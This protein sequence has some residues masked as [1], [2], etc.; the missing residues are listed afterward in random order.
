VI[1]PPRAREK[2]AGPI[3]VVDDDEDILR[4]VVRVLEVKGRFE[5]IARSAAFGLSALV[6]AE[7]PTV[8][9][10]DVSMPGLDGPAVWAVAREAVEP[11][12][13]VV[14]YSG[15]D[16]D[17]LA[18]IEERFPEARCLSKPAPFPELVQVVT[19]AHRRAEAARR[20]PA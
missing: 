20:G 13:S 18:R 2:L 11:P 19:E 14:F 6:R 17:A 9:V 15:T 8:V 5:V 1:T 4:I 16:P 3:V 7:R 10:L 12:P